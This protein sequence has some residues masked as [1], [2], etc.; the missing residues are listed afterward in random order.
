[1]KLKASLF[2]LIGTFLTIIAPTISV[3]QGWFGVFDSLSQVS[4]Q[5]TICTGYHFPNKPTTL[6]ID[7][8]GDNLVQIKKIQQSFNVQGLWTELV[9]PVRTPIPLGFA[10]DFGWLFPA[11]TLS[12]ETYNIASG[13]GERT[14]RTSTQM[15]H[16]E[17]AATYRF[18][19]S[20]SG[21]LGFRYDSFMTR[22]FSPE[23]TTTTGLTFAP[24]N[25]ADLTFSADIPFVGLLLERTMMYGCNVKAGVTWLPTLA[26]QI[27]YRE[28]VGQ[29]TLG[30]KGITVVREFSSGYFLEA[31]A[32]VSAPIYRRGQAGAFV[33]YSG[34]N[35]NAKN[36]SA[37]LGT[38]PNTTTA[39]TSEN[40]GI[41]F[42]RSSWIVGG[43][44]SAS[45]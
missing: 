41:N 12:T 20:L 26:G 17:V 42:K 37:A 34:I 19:P 24:S 7:M 11:N 31:V 5:P 44:I 6:S 18:F 16:F 39:I 14:W 28:V 9:I 38:A 30:A 25:S 3:A 29:D 23:W 45:F 21:I 10:I 36:A 27:E 32:E 40:T 33:K 2:S 43:T 35:G 13:Y 8:S 15:C 1:M 22:F 4:I